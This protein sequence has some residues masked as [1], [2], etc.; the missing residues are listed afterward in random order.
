MHKVLLVLT[1]FCII[2]NVLFLQ[3]VQSCAILDSTSSR[4][5][6]LA[7]VSHG[8]RL[9]WD[10]PTNVGYDWYYPSNS[11]GIDY[12]RVEVSG[13]PLNFQT[14]NAS[15]TCVI[16]Q[17][18]PVCYFDWRIATVTGLTAGHVYYYRVLAGTIIGDGQ[19]STTL[20]SPRIPETLV[21]VTCPNNTQCSGC[22]FLDDC[23]CNAGYDGNQGDTCTAC[24]S[25]T[26]K[27]SIG[28]GSCGPCANGTYG[29]T[30]AS[31]CVGCPANSHAPTSST[32]ITDCTCNAGYYGNFID[33]SACV[34]CPANSNSPVSSTVI[35]ACMC[36]AGYYGNATDTCMA[37]GVGKYTGT[38]GT[39][40]CTDCVAGTY[41]AVTGASVCTQCPAGKFKSIVGTALCTECVAGTYSVV[42]GVSLCSG[43][44][45]AK[46]SAAGAALCTGC[47]DRTYSYVGASDCIS[48]CNA[49]YVAG[50]FI[51]PYSS[52][53]CA[54]FIA[55]TY[56]P[57]LASVST[58]TNAGLGTLPTYN[59]VGGPSGKGHVT[60]DRTFSQF[61]NSG[62]HTM[63]INTNGG[64]TLVTVMRVTG[65]LDEQR[66]EYIM[67]MVV[68]GLF[69]CSLRT[70]NYFNRIIFDVYNAGTLILRLYAPNE[71]V[72]GT[73]MKVV[74]TYRVSDW[75]VSLTVDNSVS[76]GTPTM[77][78][79]DKAQSTIFIGK[80]WLTGLGN[81]LDRQFSGDIAGLLMVDEYLGTNATTAIADAMVNGVDLADTTCPYGNQ[82]TACATGKYKGLTATGSEPCT[83][84][85]D[86]SNS[87]TASVVLT[88]CICNVGYT[89]PNGG[90][91]TACVAGTYKNTTGS[92]TCLD[93]PAGTYSTGN[94]GSCVT[95]HSNSFSL[96]RSS[97]FSAC[98][99]NIG[100]Q[101][102]LE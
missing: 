11:Y 8:F 34:R 68:S 40:L 37:C 101:G 49:G 14:L 26:F 57:S 7:G 50:N 35:T 79:S 102:R 28:F 17:N 91:C 36:N 6:Y 18:D 60:F 20:T 53:A 52:T 47:L 46:Y 55:V 61:L 3:N 83:D 96:A 58:Y 31:V 87:V 75:M 62:P 78:W 77:L 99:C 21:A 97:S 12:Y 45:A 42:S 59:P 2:L 94:S 82:C 10:R 38:I 4:C 5:K 84:C 9:Y 1:C 54:R 27:P 95:C 29:T 15:V 66:N 73:W 70:E 86:G 39:S 43:C 25:G 71:F 67:N 51:L 65:P 92:G 74:V 89:G 80:T 32:V 23:M 93:C 63:N 85:P 19:T 90:P 76:T 81:M 24:V 72:R 13:D 69:E 64:F 98:V 100:Y 44:P 56:K 48:Q 16:D 33:T 30:M 22:T 88:D 41:S